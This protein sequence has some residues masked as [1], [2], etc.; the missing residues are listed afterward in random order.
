MRRNQRGMALLLCILALMVLTG[1]GVGLMYMTTSEALVNDNYKNSQQAYFAAVAGVQN[2]RDR[3]TPNLIGPPASPRAL[4]NTVPTT[5]PGNG[6]SVLYVLNPTAGEVT[7]PLV[8]TAGSS[9]KFFDGELA[10]ELT[11]EQN[12]VACG[13]NCY[14]SAAEDSGNLGAFNM[15]RLN[16]KWV[17]VA[18]KANGSAAPNFVNGPNPVST[19][20]NSQVCW[21]GSHEVLLGSPGVTACSNAKNALYTPVYTLTA[22]GVTPSGATRMAQGEVALDPPLTTRGAVDSQDHVNLS[23]KLD[24]NGFDYCTCDTSACTTDKSGNSTCPNRAGTTCDNSKWAVY[25]A[26]TV[27]NPNGSETFTSGHNPPNAQNQTWPYDLQSLVDRFKPTA[28][29]VTTSPYNWSCTGSPAT[30]GTKANQQ[31]GVPPTFPPSPP[32]NPAGPANMAT[33]VTYVPGDVQLTSGA[34]GNGILIVDGNLDVHGGMTFYG[35][36]IVTGVI[37][38]TGGG[39]D[40]VNLYGGIIAGKQSLVDNALGGSMNMQFDQCAL[41]SR[42]DSQ[43]PRMLSLREITF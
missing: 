5:M 19:T 33:Q 34:S 39:S 32:A 24:V 23:G 1:I 20:L 31:F 22:L 25:A 30:C 36:I 26:S 35:L 21:D 7:L 37:S 16:Y 40:K 38:F 42:D 17:R 18:L 2:A 28:V 10:T 8:Y 3:L 15:G 11:N 13:A 6:N 29:D 41:P 27:D 43:P 9:N 12:G 4:L 14:Y